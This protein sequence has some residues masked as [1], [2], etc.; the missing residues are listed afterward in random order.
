MKRFVAFFALVLLAL[1]ARVSAQD[2]APPEGWKIRTDR[3]DQDASELYFVEMPPGFHVTSG[4]AAIYWHPDQTA[5]GSYRVEME[6]FLFDPEGRREAF[7]LFMGGSDLEGPG[8]RYTYFLIRDGGEFLVK[9]RE[10]E[11]TGTVRN[12]TAHPAVLGYADREEGDVTTRNV[13]TADVGDE[14]V[15]FSINGDEVARV[16][17]EGLALDGVVGI[18]VNHR[19][20]LHIARLEISRGG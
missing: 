13:L 15:V 5:A 19:L 16:P 10:G 4:P 6:V 20:N 9:T 14:E 12:W 18:R 1:P 17:R 7:G 11:E 3:P 2:Q 8:Q